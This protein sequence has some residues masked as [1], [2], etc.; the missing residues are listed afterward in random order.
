MSVFWL[1]ALEKLNEIF[2]SGSAHHADMELFLMLLLTITILE[3]YCQGQDEGCILEKMCLL[4]EFEFTLQQSLKQV[5]NLTMWPA[6]SS[7]PKKGA[8]L[9]STCL[10][11]I[12]PYPVVSVI[13]IR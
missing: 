9:I 2:Q 12:S 1:V 5:N 10:L 4:K 3:I 8:L 13:H 6:L 11:N 7:L